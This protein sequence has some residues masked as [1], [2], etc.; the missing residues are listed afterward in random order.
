MIPYRPPLPGWP[1][2]H[3]GGHACCARWPPDP[4]RLRPQRSGDPGP[5]S[6]TACP[7]IAGPVSATG[8]NSRR[9]QPGKA[10]GIPAPTHRRLPGRDRADHRPALTASSASSTWETGHQS[11]LSGLVEDLRASAITRSWWGL[12]PT[13]ARL[14]QVPPGCSPPSGRGRLLGQVASPGTIRRSPSSTSSIENGRSHGCCRPGTLPRLRRWRL[15][16]SRRRERPLHRL[17]MA[18]G[19]PHP[20]GSRLQRNNG[21]SSQPLQVRL[22]GC[23]AA[24]GWAGSAGPWCQRRL[25]TGCAW[26]M[27]REALVRPR[28]SSYLHS[29]QRP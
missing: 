5:C 19:L 7:V 3:P 9:R 13:K 24:A 22:A 16:S 15:P 2:H 27:Q 10:P 1:L 20:S 25:R 14:L 12:A 11:R 23:G 18:R 29:P 4:R 17:A 21:H 28:L 6:T 8:E 26:C